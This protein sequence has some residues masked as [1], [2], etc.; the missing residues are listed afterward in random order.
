ML[1][2][3]FDHRVLAS[4]PMPG[5]EEV[6]RLL[7]VLNAVV[8]RR[9]LTYFRKRKMTDAVRLARVAEQ[10]TIERMEDPTSAIDITSVVTRS[11]D[12]WTL[13]IHEQVFDYL[14]FV[15]P[16]DPDQRLVDTPPEQRKGLAFAEFMLRHELEH[17]IYPGLEERD[18][19]RS[20]CDFAMDRR[21]SDPTYYQTLRAALADPMTGLNG[22]QY[23]DLLDR[24]E[25]SKECSDLIEAMTTDHLK[26]AARLPD[27]VLRGAFPIMGRDTKVAIASACYAASHGGSRPLLERA[28]WLH[29]MLALLA[30]E[31]EK[32]R[33]EGKA[34]YTILHQRLDMPSLLH[35]IEL[36]AEALAGKSED[37]AFEL[38]STRLTDLARERR[39]AGGGGARATK[40]MEPRGLDKASARMSLS[41]R[42]EAARND[43][44]VPRSVIDTI[45]KNRSATGGVSGAKYNELIETLLAI[46]WGKIRP[47]G[48]TPEEFIKGLDA[49]HHGLERPKEIL[50]D[51]FTNLIWRYR[52]FSRE[53]V[54]SWHQTGSAFLLVGPPGVGKTS[55]AISAAQNLGIPFHKLS[56]G[57]MRD[58][59][60][61]R[62]HGF[63]YEGSKP[64]G[65]VQGLVKM[66]AM[67]GMFI[68]DEADKTE[69]FAI[70]TLLE[71]L[72]PEQN[73]LFHDK[74][75][76]TTVDIDLSNCHFIL[77]A[78]TLETVPDPVADR[79]EIVFLDRYS[80]EEKMAIAVEHLLPRVRARH[81]IA[82]DAV[83]FAPEE[84]T[85]LLRHLIT[86]YTREAGV[87]QLERVL[88]TLFLRVHRKEVMGGEGKPVRLTREL[89][90]RYLDE[91]T[92]PR[93]I[94]PEDRVGEM[95]GLGV[96]V[97]RGVGSII[98]IQATPVL[99]GEEGESRQGR[100]SL[101]ETTGNLEKVMD[102]SRKVALTGIGFCGEELGIARESLQ[103][104]LHLH[105]MGASSRKDGPSAGGAIALALASRLTAKKVRRDVAMTG[106]IDTQ[107]RITAVGGLDVKLESA[108]E[109]GC[110]TVVIPRENLYGEFG[111]ERFPQ[112][113]KEE[114]QVLTF[115]EWETD[116][117]PFDY[118]KHLLQVVAVDHV[119]AAAKVAFVD[120][121]DLRPA[122]L[123]VAA[124]GRRAADTLARTGTHPSPCVQMLYLKSSQELHPRHLRGAFC[125]QCRGCRLLV[126]TEA[127][128]DVRG[129]LPHLDE[130]A[131]LEAFDPSRDD[132][133]PLLADLLAPCAD[134]G[135][136]AAVAPYFLLTPGGSL[137]A[138]LPADG[139][140][141]RLMANNY[142]VQGVKIKNCKAA[143]NRAACYLMRLGPA[144]LA[145]CPF[146]AELEGILV[147]DLSF[148][149]EKY[150]LDVERAE[151]IFTRSVDAWLNEVETRLV[152]SSPGQPAP[153]P[154]P[155]SR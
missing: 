13:H 80:V 47:I 147:A 118:R 27:G 153:M 59:A 107:G 16:S 24:L 127:E 99:L 89:I 151:T 108:Y 104:P 149:P 105:F 114:L 95:L 48:V 145:A 146:V 3:R 88:R 126:V 69:K 142:A 50:A 117:T 35:E 63:T 75:A 11:V 2:I 8:A 51:F 54:A 58:E 91:P 83:F 121:A 62:G 55:L 87:R 136:V 1:P 94:N 101:L 31:M 103:R 67:N 61:L 5:R 131:R 40:S 39:A 15:I 137:R 81:D 155:P 139:R 64:G 66:G 25:N 43:A 44:L 34:I 102:E 32:D 12:G 38:F 90:K 41:D 19:V 74:Y 26:L 119:V 78:N 45:D 49:S 79:C 154:G 22:G 129:Q 10:Y 7:A 60:D 123:L 134:G 33:A 113:L 96:D 23:L 37:D 9:V 144:D 124:H 116:H 120:E 132:L 85:E 21:H 68:M 17:M 109:A 14:A 135:S 128:R 140:S 125:T 76:S 42:I 53:Q 100:V 122:E 71:I 56:L 84:R 72:D 70:A 86:T 4:L 112:A 46:P 30:D 138:H 28:D 143:L 97:Q 115:E 152:A 148:I 20:D 36:P 18:A 6:K 52:H 106:E 98:P 130:V 133:E 73:F 77:T 29:K 82:P 65:I 57:G 93:Q 150:R 141:V 110:R 92:P 111:V